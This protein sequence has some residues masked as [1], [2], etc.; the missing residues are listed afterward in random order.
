MNPYLA[1]VLLAGIALLQTTLAP[2]VS[3]TGAKPQLMLLAVVSW[4]LLRGG[5][6]GVVWGFIGG[7]ML[8]F[9]SGGP[10]GIFTLSLILVGYVSGVGEINVF[11]VHFLWLGMIV[12]MATWF[13]NVIT[14]GLLQLLRQPVAWEAGLLHVVLPVVL[15]NILALPLIYLPLHRLHRLTG[16]PQMDW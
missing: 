10:F 11:R 12:V 16:E 15:L 6:A 4:S 14:L 9:L 8:D 2:H 13:Y 7:L 5:R 1:V 3:F